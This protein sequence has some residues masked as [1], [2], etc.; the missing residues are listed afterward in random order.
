VVAY[1]YVIFASAV[2]EKVLGETPVASEADEAA[3]VYIQTE[4]LR[5]ALGIESSPLEA[6][7]GDIA[8]KREI[9]L[10]D[11][12]LEGDFVRYCPVDHKSQPD[13]IE[14]LLAVTLGP[15]ESGMVQV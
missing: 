13:V 10:P 7:G 5:R 12:G 9:H 4:A 1:R 3:A 6:S 2:V 14:V 15:P 8:V 11:S